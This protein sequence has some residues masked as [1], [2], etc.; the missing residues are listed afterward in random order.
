MSLGIAFMGLLV[1]TLVGLTGVG[2]ASILTPILVLVGIHPSVAVGT[3]LVYNA[4][5]KLFG[6][7]QHVRQKTVNFQIVRHLAYGSAPSVVVTILFMH[8]YPV[9][10]RHEEIV[11]KHVIG[12]VLILVA[13][14]MIF[15]VAFGDRLDLQR[16]STT[17]PVEHRRLA[18][19][20]GAGFGILVGLTSI[21]AGSLFSIVMLYLYRLTA[22]EFVGTDIAHAF[23]ISALAGALN[24]GFGHV[25]GPLVA[26]LLIGSV[27]GVLLGS[28]LSTKMAAKPLRVVMSILIFISG[29][30][31][32]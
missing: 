27:P 30:R 21:G 23:I 25:N 3:D 7:W 13:S 24:I 20:F 18:I 5:T 28:R 19:A 10:H 4:I 26:N 14:A 16:F 1:G 31:L 2:G 8:F 29:F 32:V 22:S 6:S 12:Y 15:R 9:L 17:R 11:M